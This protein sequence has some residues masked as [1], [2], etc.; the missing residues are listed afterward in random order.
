VWSATVQEA[1]QDYTW[2][3]RILW[4]SSFLLNK[5]SDNSLN[6]KKTTSYYALFTTETAWPITHKLIHRRYIVWEQG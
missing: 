3:Y 4:F 1:L 5:L 2:L 6:G